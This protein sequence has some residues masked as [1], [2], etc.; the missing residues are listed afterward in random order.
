VIGVNRWWAWPL[1]L[2]SDKSYVLEVDEVT[3]NESTE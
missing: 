1:I 2:L 3:C